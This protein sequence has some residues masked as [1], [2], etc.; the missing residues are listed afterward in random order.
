MDC[1]YKSNNLGDGLVSKLKENGLSEIEMTR[2][3]LDFVIA[4][5]DTVLITYNCFIGILEMEK[6]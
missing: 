5:G 2:I 4:A 1:I 3:A 6:F